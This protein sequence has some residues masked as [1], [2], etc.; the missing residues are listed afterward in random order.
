MKFL[1][2]LA[3]F[4]LGPLV[5]GLAAVKGRYGGRWMERLGFKLAQTRRPNRPRI[6]VHGASV[7]EARSAASVINSLLDQEPSCEV[8]FTVGTPAGLKTAEDIF[9]GN[10]RVTIIAAPL[11]FWGAPH[12]A[13]ARLKPDVL[14]IMETEL[15]PN[16][17]YEANRV[18]VK[19]VLGAARLSERSFRR[20]GL[21]KAFMAQLLNKFDLI[22][23]SGPKEAE[24]YHALGAPTSRLTILGNP[25]FDNLLEQAQS[26]E[27]LSQIDSWKQKLAL[28][29]PHQ[30]LLVVGSTH[31]G[32]NEI[33]IKAYRELQPTKMVIAP[34]HLPDVPEVLKLLSQSGFN[35]TLASDD[36][37]SSAQVVVLDSVGHLPA[38]YALADVAVV[39]GSFK[40]ELTGHNPLEPAAVG[41]PVVFGPHMASFAREAEGL[42]KCGGAFEARPENLGQILGKLFDGSQD[43]ILAGEKARNYL[44][45]QP[46]AAPALA[47][48]ILRIALEKPVA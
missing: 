15:W 16:L 14:V 6:W 48:N 40:P 33:I 1:Y 2:S 39:G 9:S 18:G 5:V 23:P 7:G 47:G 36:R 43:A 31:L 29:D 35:A 17:I 11:D 22:A 37:A 10:S 4:S 28:H 46:K 41:K 32:E 21:V 44:A 26:T 19:L 34:R 24:Y 13:L 12:R 38:I 20:Y 30:P 3:A 8:F 27:F 25:K 42:L 45:A